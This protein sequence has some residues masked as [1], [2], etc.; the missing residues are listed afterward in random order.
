MTVRY[1]PKVVVLEGRGGQVFVA[2]GPVPERNP[3]FDA[4]FASECERLPRYNSDQPRV[5]AGQPGAGEWSSG[6]SAGGTRD[7]GV[8]SSGWLE[9][10]AAQTRYLVTDIPAA[11]SSDQ[12]NFFEEI[13]SLPSASPRTQR[14][15]VQNNFAAA[16]AAADE[17]DVPVENILG[18]AAL[19]SSWG[20][21][22]FAAQGNNMFNLGV[23]APGTNGFI[24]SARPP[25]RKVGRFDDPKDSFDSFVQDT[26]IL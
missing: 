18:L 17:L 19:E 1:K 10:V 12:T 7:A 9:S 4:C 3:E 13:S 22:T 16:S 5:P 24:E 26:Q 11:D 6:G 8:S 2:L 21:S 14:Q 25:H 15:F 20:R 23:D